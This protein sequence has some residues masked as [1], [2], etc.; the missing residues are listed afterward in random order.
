MTQLV[1]WL[2]WLERCTG[3]AEVWFRIPANCKPEFLQAFT[4][5]Q[6]SEFSPRGW[7][8]KRTRRPLHC[9]K[10]SIQTDYTFAKRFA[11]KSS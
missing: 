11:G 8:S 5:A 4:N 6:V 3:I 10:L 2:N 9:C 1:C 7:L